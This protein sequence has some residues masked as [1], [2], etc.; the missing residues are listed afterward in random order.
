[1]TSLPPSVPDLGERRWLL[2]RD[3]AGFCIKLTLEALR[4]IVLIPLAVAAG[5]LGILLGGAEPERFFRGVLEAGRRFDA[6]LDLFGRR[7]SAGP[8]LDAQLQRLEAVLREHAQ[9]GGVTAQARAAIDR[10]LDALQG[11]SARDRRGP[12]ERDNSGDD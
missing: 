6:W 8:S 2:I 7:E 3:L 5:A 1:M 4:D 11:V 9:R 10:T 12:A